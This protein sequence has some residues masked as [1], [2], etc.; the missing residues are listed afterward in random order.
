MATLTK[1]KTFINGELLT[2]QKL[3]ELVD[4]G[5]VSGIVNAD[6]ANNAAIADS[7]LAQITTANKVANSATTATNA[8]TANTIVARDGSGNFSAGTITA[9]L[10]G[11]AATATT[12]Q[13]AR[14]INGVSFNGGGNITVMA[15]PNAHTHGNITDAGA[16]GTTA[17]LPIITG[18]NGVLQAGSF[19]T[20]AGTFCQGNDARLSDARTPTSHNHDASAITVGTLPNARTTATPDNTALT[21]VARDASGNFSA[22]RITAT[23]IAIGASTPDASARLDIVST[24]QGFLPP[25][26]STAQR[27]AIAAPA[28]GLMVYNTTTNKLQVRTNTAWIDLH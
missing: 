24:T 3:H 19:G 18:T 27:D 2:P 7:K 10:S 15:N 9:A 23:Q 28:V 25:R 12:L 6:I 13:T 17:S 22:A 16:I 1:G 21:I 20:T 14:T 11:N 5:A 4:L 26:M 8:N